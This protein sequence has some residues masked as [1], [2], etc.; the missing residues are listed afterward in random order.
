MNLNSYYSEALRLGLMT[1]A[2]IERILDVQKEL[3]RD[4]NASEDE[5]FYSD[6]CIGCYYEFLPLGD[7]STVIINK[8][9]AVLVFDGWVIDSKSLLDQKGSLETVWLTTERNEKVEEYM[10]RITAYKA[11]REFGGKLIQKLYSIG[12]VGEGWKKLRA[13]VANA[14][15]P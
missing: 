9:D 2:D 15:A 3:A 8:S 5:I 14:I 7:S 6:L 13:K 11:Y 4:F 12:N 10:D 1:D